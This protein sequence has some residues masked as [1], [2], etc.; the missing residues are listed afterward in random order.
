MPDSHDGVSRRR[1]ILGTSVFAAATALPW[2]SELLAVNELDGAT[3]EPVQF[4]TDPKSLARR[5]DALLNQIAR[6]FG[7]YGQPRNYVPLIQFDA[8][9]HQISEILKVYQPAGTALEIL[10][11]KAQKQQDTVTDEQNAQDHL[12]VLIK[13]LQR[14]QTFAIQ[15]VNELADIIATLQI[16]V[17]TQREVLNAREAEYKAAVAAATGGCSLNEALTIVSAI[18][19]VVGAAFTAGQSLWLLA[20]TVAS[21]GLAIYKSVTIK[22]PDGKDQQVSELNPTYTKFATAIGDI[23]DVVA[24]Y[25]SL[26][27][28]LGDNSDS[29]RVVIPQADFDHLTSTFDSDVDKAEGV[30]QAVKD[31]FKEAAHRFVDLVQARNKKI[32]ERDGALLLISQIDLSIHDRTL[33]IQNLSDKIA[34]TV[35]PPLQEYVGMLSRMSA[36]SNDYIRNLLWDEIRGL[37]LWKLEPISSNL[38]QLFGK[39]VTDLVIT[40]TQLVSEFAVDDVGDPGGPQPFSSRVQITVPVSKAQA[41]QFSGHRSFTFSIHQEKFESYMDEIVVRDVTLEVVGLETFKG[42]LVHLGRH[43]FRKRDGKTTIEYASPPLYV[44]I[45]SSTALPPVPLGTADQKHF[46]VSPLA[47]WM[48]LPEDEISSTSLAGITAIKLSF[49]GRF[50][51]TVGS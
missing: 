51:A 41:E 33:E 2:T 30:D 28:E 22:G 43:S 5:A 6:G 39:S 38:T 47:D 42:R 14:Q 25:N 17:Q 49:D 9:Q 1:F 7:Y 21:S 36:A 40:H 32:I 29:A 46:G 34:K 4:I 24:K 27:K 44:G 37:A 11:D 50:R 45:Q 15:L 8:L 16:E 35:N 19:A 12:R 31:A 23:K 3:T 20:G 10:L 48:L 26:K 18:V 13:D